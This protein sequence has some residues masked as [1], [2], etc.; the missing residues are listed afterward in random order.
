V[1]TEHV[2][3]GSDPIDRS[4]AGAAP[5]RCVAV[6]LTGLL[7]GSVTGAGQ[8]AAPGAS[9]SP[10][11]ATPAAK[12]PMSP[13]G[14]PRSQFAERYYAL[15]FGVNQMHARYTASG[16]SVEFRYR[17]VNPD[18]ATVLSDKRITP[19]MIDEQTGIRLMV[20]TA[21]QLGALRQTSPPQQGREYW[22]LFANAGKVVKPGQ[23]VDVSI[24]PFQVRGLTV[25]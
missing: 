14:V 8:A 3:R 1:K 7:A 17:V 15:R 10:I 2:S 6:L 11:A 12:T 25:E 5:G 23:R 16:A 20:H 18:K 24:G 22:I 9:A 13:L 19:Y 4:H 21:E